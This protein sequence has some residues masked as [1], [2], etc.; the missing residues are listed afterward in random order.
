M[1]Y[2]RS[3]RL[4]INVLKEEYALSVGFQRAR[5]ESIEREGKDGGRKDG[6]GKEGRGTLMT[7]P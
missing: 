6:G 2:V 4:G 7:I 1:R 3:E 5:V